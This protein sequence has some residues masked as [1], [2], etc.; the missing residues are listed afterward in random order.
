MQVPT[1]FTRYIESATF[2]SSYITP[3]ASDTIKESLQKTP[4]KYL[5]LHASEGWWV[6]ISFYNRKNANGRIYS[7]K[8]W[9]NVINKQKDFYKYCPML[10]DHP[11]GDADGNPKDICGVWLDAKLGPADANGE[12]LVYGLLVPSGHIGEDLKDHLSKGLKV[13]T[14]SSGFGK[15]LSDGV[16]VDPDSFVIERLSDWVLNPSQGTFFSYDEDCDD[17][18]N[19]SRQQESIEIKT[20]NMLTENIREKFVKDSKIA[21]LE[22]KKFRRDMESFLED[23]SN[24]RD[25]QERLEE[26]KEIRSYLEEGACPD[27][28]EKIEQKIAEEEAFIATALREKVELQELEI[29]S[30]KD[31]KEKLTKIVEDA[32]ILNEEAKEWKAI[33]EELQNKLT[34]TSKEL[35][36]RPTQAY[37]EYLKERNIVVENNLKENKE[38]SS[39][40]LKAVTKAYMDSATSVKALQEN[41]EDLKK[42]N[43]SLREKV[44]SFKD[45]TLKAQNKLTETKSS[46]ESSAL[47]LKESQNRIESLIKVV[48][49]QKAAIEKLTTEN[50]EIREN[51]KKNAIELQKTSRALK[52]AEDALAA[53]D[54]AEFLE[55]V[56]A[57]KTPCDKYYEALYST[58]GEQLL[59]FEKR[60]RNSRTLVEAKRYF[61]QEVLQN[62]E[63]TKEIDRDRIPESL[64]VDPEDRARV[65]GVSNFR[66]ATS[67][68]RKPTGWY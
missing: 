49:A 38:K 51:F 20:D 12:G 24:I 64:Y 8:L 63:E 18:V 43:D 48:E 11:A 46:V 14:S 65:L 9:E 53:I 35:E 54:D 32:A 67:V 60:I 19:Q 25:P 61:F 3:V 62:L 21:K 31:L 28:K 30:P 23:A 44:A 10:A 5:N 55:E 17:M 34:E 33:S 2:D 41:I 39:E 56:E 26:F 47:Q 37:V 42:E 29:E 27:L 59:P 15:L 40:V 45:V 68:D 13:G 7:K 57:A 6:P 16:T 4:N 50:K 36:A 58:Y 1:G 52:E 66:K 22:E